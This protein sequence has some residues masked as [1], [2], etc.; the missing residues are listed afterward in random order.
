MGPYR[1]I[2]K[3]GYRITSK[4]FY[5]NSPIGYISHQIYPRRLEYSVN[6][7]QVWKHTLH[8]T[9][10]EKENHTHTGFAHQYITLDMSQKRPIHFLIHQPID[11]GFTP[12]LTPIIGWK[13]PL[14]NQKPGIKSH[15]P[16]DP[17]TMTGWHVNLCPVNL[18]TCQPV[19]LQIQVSIKAESTFHKPTDEAT[20]AEKLFFW[21]GSNFSTSTLLSILTLTHPFLKCKRTFW[22]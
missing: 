4:N 10:V 17:S 16:H 8:L 1:Y 2:S 22:D 3:I 14:T 19:N 18:Q 21:S 6:H 7:I 12:Y 20:I 11:L 15:D 5:H 9:I 13:P